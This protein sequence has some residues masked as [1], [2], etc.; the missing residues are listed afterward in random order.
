MFSGGI[1]REQL[2]GM[3]YVAHQNHTETHSHAQ[4]ET[5]ESFLSNVLN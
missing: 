2:H 4:S 5:W 3:G 1:K